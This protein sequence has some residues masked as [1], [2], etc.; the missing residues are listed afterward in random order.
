MLWDYLILIWCNQCL[1]GNSQ[2]SFPA[3]IRCCCIVVTLTDTFVPITSQ[4]IHPH[5]PPHSV[6]PPASISSPMS[7]SQG[8]GARPCCHGDTSQ[9]GPAELDVGCSS[10]GQLDPE[11]AFFPVVAP[12]KHRAHVTPWRD[13]DSATRE[14][15]NVRERRASPGWFSYPCTV[16]VYFIFIRSWVVSFK[17]ARFE[18]YHSLGG[19]HEQSVQIVI[20]N[21][22]Q[23][24]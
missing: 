20:H 4:S 2:T 23:E 9:P 5:V 18:V 7:C 15:I 1:E 16:K 10:D 22:K 3:L 19:L 11:R 12:L 17:A 24:V 14:E 8:T 21:K 6:L 13:D